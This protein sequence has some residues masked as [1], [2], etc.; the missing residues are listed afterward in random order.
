MN[1]INWLE[2]FLAIIGLFGWCM[3]VLKLVDGWANRQYQNR[4]HQISAARTQEMNRI[5]L[6]ELQSS[7]EAV[8]NLH[9]ML[10]RRLLLMDARLEALLAHKISNSQPTERGRRRSIRELDA[11]HERPG[12]YAS[13][14]ELPKR[15]IN[16]FKAATQFTLRKPQIYYFSQGH[17]YILLILVIVAYCPPD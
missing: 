3:I 1:E 11:S 4:M 10:D 13:Q 9:Y 2:L 16:D 6:N 12:E 8:E 15:C 7:L 14:S 17:Q 5:L